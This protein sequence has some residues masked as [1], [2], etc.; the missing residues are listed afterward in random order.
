MG[1]LGIEMPITM[2][3]FTVG[4][5][6]MVGIP[7]FVGFNSKWNFAAAILDSGSIWVMIALAISS[8]LNALY[9]LPVVVRAFFGSE[10]KEKAQN[11]V[12][13]E[14]PVSALLPIITLSVLVVLVAVFGGPLSDMIRAGI[15]SIQ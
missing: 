14:R 15:A 7:L 12:S 13:L 9:Y 2:A 6:S 4:A 3:L 1:G 10:A 5:L 11:R 8:L